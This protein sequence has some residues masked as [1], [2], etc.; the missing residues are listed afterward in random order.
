MYDI[1]HVSSLVPRP[2]LSLSFAVTILEAGK[3]ELVNNLEAGKKELVNYA[4]LQN[5]YCKR[6]RERRPGNEA[7]MFPLAFTQIGHVGYQ[8]KALLLRN[9]VCN[10]NIKVRTL[11]QRPL[12]LAQ[13]D[14]T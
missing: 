14:P 5:C 4:C 12:A 8:M 11:D 3:K 1:R 6:K 2:S 13:N 9:T 7:N 10:L